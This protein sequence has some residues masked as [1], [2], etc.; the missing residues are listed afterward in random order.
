MTGNGLI[1]Q[2]AA[3]ILITTD[4]RLLLQLRDDL[5]QVFDPGKIGLFGGQR[6]GDES[7]LECVVREVHEEISLYLPPERFELIGSYFGPDQWTPNGTRHSEIFVA[8]DVPIDRLKITEGA[9]RIV[10]M[11]ELKHIHDLLAPFAKHALETLLNLENVQ[12]SA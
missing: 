7:F 12:R 5:P 11:D 1:R 4:F 6:E 3:A 2:G 8:Y 9:L 10:A